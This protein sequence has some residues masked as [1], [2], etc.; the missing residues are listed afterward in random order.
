MEVV[1]FI[2]T[3]PPFIWLKFKQKCWR[4]CHEVWFEPNEK[5]CYLEKCWRHLGYR[6]KTYQKFSIC[7]VIVTYNF[8]EDIHVSV[9]W[10]SKLDVSHPLSINDCY[11]NA[12][13]MAIGMT[14]SISPSTTYLR[15]TDNKKLQKH[16]CSQRMYS[17]GSTYV[18][19][20]T[21]C[22]NVIDPSTFHP[23]P[24]GLNFIWLNNSV[25][26]QVPVS[27]LMSLSWTLWWVDENGINYIY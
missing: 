24:S 7:L 3:K 20:K 10:E 14:M 6:D 18:P 22:S 1:V 9:P 16:K 19:L 4:K 25:I 26:G 13:H 5:R 12:N 11:S 15:K 21:K 8:K 23:S 27:N 17:S 2:V